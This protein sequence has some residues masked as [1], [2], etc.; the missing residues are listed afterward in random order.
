MDLNDNL[1]SDLDAFRIMMAERYASTMSK[2]V[3]QYIPNHAIS[4]PG[5]PERDHG[6]RRGGRALM[7]SFAK[8][9]EC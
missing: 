5:P 7:Q 9:Y 3:R 2:L 6:E 8:Y 4:N 1:R